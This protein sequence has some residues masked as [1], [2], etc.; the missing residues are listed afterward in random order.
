MIE[1]AFG[2]SLFTLALISLYL[3]VRII[4]ILFD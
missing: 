3:L 1:L 2:I 4:I